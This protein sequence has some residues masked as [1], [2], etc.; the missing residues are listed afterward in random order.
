MQG[1]KSRSWLILLRTRM[2]GTVHTIGLLGAVGKRFLYKINGHWPFRGGGG[3][4]PQA[5]KHYT[6]TSSGFYANSDFFLM[7]KSIYHDKIFHRNRPFMVI[8]PSRLLLR[9]NTPF[10]CIQEVDDSLKSY[11]SIYSLE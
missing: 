2:R 3:G 7:K 6:K 5:V 1:N 10:L 8:P 4:E 9:P 11:A